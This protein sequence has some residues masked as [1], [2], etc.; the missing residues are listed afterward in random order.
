MKRIFCYLFLFLFMFPCFNIG[1]CQTGTWWNEDFNFRVGIN[2]DSVMDKG[3]VTIDFQET[4]DDLGIYPFDPN[5]G[6]CEK[7]DP[8]SLRLIEQGNTFTEKQFYWQ[9][10]D[11]Y[12]ADDFESGLDLWKVGTDVYADLSQRY[13][14]GD[15]LHFYKNTETGVKLR[16]MIKADD[17]SEM[18]YFSFYGKGNF[19]ITLRDPAMGTF[20]FDKI[21]TSTEFK[22]EIIPLSFENF[23]EGVTYYLELSPDDFVTDNWADDM[24]FIGD[25]IEMDF[26]K[27]EGNLY[28]YFN[29]FIT[30]SERD[31]SIFSPITGSTKQASL[32]ELQGFRIQFENTPLSPIS[33]DYEIVVNVLD[34][35]NDLEWVRYRIDWPSWVEFTDE[36]YGVWGE[37]TFDGEHWKAT[38]DTV[39]TICDG[40]HSIAVMAQDI[41]GNNVFQIADIEIGNIQDSIDLSPGT[42]EFSFA[43]VGDTQPWSGGEIN[44]LVAT[45]IMETIAT[46]ENPDFII[47]V[48]DL[49][50]A[51]HEREFVQTRKQITSFAKVPFYPVVGNHDAA[52]PVGLEI[53]ERDF[54]HVTYSFD[55]GNSHFIFLCSEMSG[56]KGLVTGNQLSW[57][58]AELSE[59]ADKENIFITIHQPI[60]PI[61]HGIDNTAEVQKVIEKYHNVRA[62]FQGHEH[63][64]YHTKTSGIDIFVTGGATWLDSQYPKENTFNHYI[65]ID[66]KDD[67]MTWR[68]EKTSHLFIETPADLTTKNSEVEIVGK[69]Q[70]YT[71]VVVSDIEVESNAR[72][73]FKTTLSLE[74]GQNT[75]SI[76]TKGMVE[77]QSASLC[78]TRL[79]ELGIVCP[80]EVIAGQSF[81]VRVTSAGASVEG[82]TVCFDEEEKQTNS[83]G[84]VFFDAPL[85]PQTT[86]KVSAYGGGFYST[87][88][89]VNVTREKGGVPIL[90]ITVGI[91]VLVAIGVFW[92]SRR[93][94]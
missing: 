39:S 58:D 64:F 10:K 24:V 61:Y 59:N 74:V 62:I 38:W 16:A 4:L 31:E 75:V 22:R 81:E 36:R 27:S 83:E 7:I 56:Q 42:D 67:E 71:T 54:G 49:N 12:I 25:V 88:N 82:V 52:A 91:V 70:P 11:Y 90:Y 86:L 94:K 50:Y 28:L 34:Q 44:P 92:I 69:T 9:P 20:V 72:G 40:H 57:L 1:S 77:D 79:G 89:I 6:F 63:T 21:F 47:Q 93:N 60:Y 8:L 45:Y 17:F 18:T 29:T 5:Y 65:M 30:T 66:V 51:G 85:L 41:K 26:E 15:A 43:V 2:Q 55:Y 80:T 19:R 78:I 73:E 13:G 87:F 3:T 53:F 68:V 76:A 14:N 48:G 35:R 84:K 23:R 37:M 46:Q 33:G 32:K